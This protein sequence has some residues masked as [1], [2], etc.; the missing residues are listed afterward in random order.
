MHML[1]RSIT[2][3][4]TGATGPPLAKLAAAAVPPTGQKR[5]EVPL[6]HSRISLRLRNTRLLFTFWAAGRNATPLHFGRSWPSAYRWHASF[7]QPYSC[8]MSLSCHLD[9]Q[10]SDWCIPAHSNL[11]FPFFPITPLLTAIMN[12]SNVLAHA[13]C[14]HLTT[15]LGL[16]IG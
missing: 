8:P 1:G 16:P 13:P 9:T 15:N 14:N 2:A 10:S 7:F 5:G 6:R 12:K 3:C 4:E 11:L